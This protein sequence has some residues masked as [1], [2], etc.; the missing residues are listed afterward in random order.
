MAA[1]L[2]SALHF[3]NAVHTNMRRAGQHETRY[4]RRRETKV[5]VP[6]APARERSPLLGGWVRIMREA[7]KGFLIFQRAHFGL[8]IKISYISSSSRPL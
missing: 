7:K 4:S 3:L 6:D 8:K 5:L 1:Y 2:R